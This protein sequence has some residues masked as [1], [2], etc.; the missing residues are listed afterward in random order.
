MQDWITVRGGLRTVVMPTASQWLDLP[1]HDD[2]LLMLDVREVTGTVTMAYQTAPSKE[3]GAFQSLLLTGPF[4]VA[5]T[6]S[7]T[8]QVNL[9]RLDRFLAAYT[10]VPIGRHIRWQLTSSSSTWD[11]TFRLWAAAYSVD[12]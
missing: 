5:V 4:T 8:P 1:D 2:L 6:A 11:V 12:G 9:P 10:P 7:G 3:D